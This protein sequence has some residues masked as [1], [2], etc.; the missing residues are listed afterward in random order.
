MNDKREF[1]EDDFNLDD[2]HQEYSKRV[3]EHYYEKNKAK[4][5]LLHFLIMMASVAVAFLLYTV[6]QNY[7][8]TLTI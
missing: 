1:I 7:I 5:N 2:F 4:F 8:N 3:E 6:L